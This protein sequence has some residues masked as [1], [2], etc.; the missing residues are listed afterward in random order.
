MINLIHKITCSDIRLFELKLK[1]IR[2]SKE[3]LLKSKPSRLRRKKLITWQN[4]LEELKKEEKV[5]ET[6][7]ESAYIDVEKFYN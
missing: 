7:L 5:V 2:L 3:K 6:E 1:R 4:K